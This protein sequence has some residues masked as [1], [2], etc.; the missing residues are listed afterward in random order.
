MPVLP[1]RISARSAPGAYSGIPPS[2]FARPLAL[3]GGEL[4]R[5]EPVRGGVQFPG[6]YVQAALAF[7]SRLVLHDNRG[8]LTSIAA[9]ASAAR[10]SNSALKSPAASFMLARNSGRPLTCKMPPMIAAHS[11]HDGDD[12]N[13]AALPAPIARPYSGSSAQD[14]LV[15]AAWRTARVARRVGG[16]G[17]AM[18][19]GRTAPFRSSPSLRE[20][21]AVIGGILQVNGLPEF[22][23]NMN[24]AAGD[25]NAELEGLAAL[26]EAA[27]EVKGATII[28]ENEATGEGERGLNVAAW[29]PIFRRAQVSGG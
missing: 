13:G 17:R 8:G 16:Y 21:A 18:G 6:R 28:V 15:F 10:P 14:P 11:A 5:Q 26:A 7:A 12:R 25:F 24:E 22:L 1:R 4:I 2:L 20:W 27:M 9:S 23:A 19:A 3:A 29:E